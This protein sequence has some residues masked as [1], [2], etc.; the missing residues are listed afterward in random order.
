MPD[1]ELM[2][3]RFVVITRRRRRSDGKSRKTSG[4]D[5]S[6]TAPGNEKAKERTRWTDGRT[7]GRAA[8]NEERGKRSVAVRRRGW[9]TIAKKEQ[10]VEENETTR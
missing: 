8:R 3:D 7:D 4:R 5:S 1:G 10:E 2:R 9:E 6:L